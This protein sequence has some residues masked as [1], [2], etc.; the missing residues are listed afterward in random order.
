MKSIKGAV[1]LR[2][3]LGTQTFF[4]WLLTP[5][6]WGGVSPWVHLLKLRRHS[7]VRHWA[8]MK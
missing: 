7:V 4:F 2:P 3:I 6:T 1:N 8:V 5:P